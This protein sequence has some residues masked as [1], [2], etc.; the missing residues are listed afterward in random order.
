MSNTDELCKV[1]ASGLTHEDIIM[2]DARAK[3][4]VEGFKDGIQSA[5]SIEI[6]RCGEC[7]NAD[8][9]GCGAGRCYCM[10]HCCYMGTDDFCS[11]GKKEGADDEQMD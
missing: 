4:Y 11:Y 8:F 9:G 3:G 10:E 6:V 2:A 5:P 7:I 1:L